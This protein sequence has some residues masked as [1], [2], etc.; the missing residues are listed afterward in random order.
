MKHKL[1][2]AA[3]VLPRPITF[4]Y[5]IIINAEPNKTFGFANNKSAKG[6]SR[7]N[8]PAKGGIFARIVS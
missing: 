7:I 3:D 4:N 2:I 5:N 8:D 6:F 1:T